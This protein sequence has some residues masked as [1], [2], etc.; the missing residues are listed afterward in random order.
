[1]TSL[2]HAFACTHGFVCL[3]HKFRCPMTLRNTLG[4]GRVDCVRTR[5]CPTT[6]VGRKPVTLVSDSVP[7]IIVTARGFVCRGIL[8]GVRRVGTHRNHIVTVIDGNSRAVSGVTSRIVR[9]PRALRYLRPLLTAVPLRL[10]TCRM[11]M[12]GNGGISR[13]EGLTGSIAMRWGGGKGHHFLAF[14]FF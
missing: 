12:Y 11:T 3:N 6:R 14:P 2:D 8:S 13:P 9:L 7:M 5:N 1:M 10:L 4:L